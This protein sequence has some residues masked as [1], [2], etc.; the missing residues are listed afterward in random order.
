MN[1]KTLL[2]YTKIMITVF[3]N[4][5]II[6][7]AH[8]RVGLV[9]FSGSGKTTFASMIARLYEIES[10]QILIDDQNIQDVTQEKLEAQYIRYSSRTD[11]IS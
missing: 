5:S 1:L 3:N 6:I 10:G 7:D 8:Q 4:K 11:F 9:G 2:F